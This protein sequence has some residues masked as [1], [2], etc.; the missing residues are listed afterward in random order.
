[1]IIKTWYHRLHNIYTCMYSREAALR[2]IR[3]VTGN[4]TYYIAVNQGIRRTCRPFFYTYNTQIHT[5]QHRHVSIL[6]HM[7]CSSDQIK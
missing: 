6:K 7:R 2:H 4:P 5:V 1:M 3:G